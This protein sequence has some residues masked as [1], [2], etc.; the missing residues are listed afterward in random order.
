MGDGLSDI[1][2]HSLR[3][4]SPTLLLAFHVAW[5]F[6]SNIVLV[7]VDFS[8]DLFRMCHEDFDHSSEYLCYAALVGGDDEDGIS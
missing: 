7:I 5:I 1:M 3:S 4:E 8:V 2:G 6:L